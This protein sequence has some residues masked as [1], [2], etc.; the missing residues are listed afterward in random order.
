MS[1]MQARRGG[2]PISIDKRLKYYKINSPGNVIGCRSIPGFRYSCNSQ[3]AK[4]SRKFTENNAANGNDF[5]E[6]ENVRFCIPSRKHN[7]IIR[8]SYNELFYFN[9]L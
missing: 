2:L 4:M 8:R 5:V 3:R 1:F 9:N 7:T 6:N